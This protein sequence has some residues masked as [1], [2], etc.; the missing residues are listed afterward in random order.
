ME[1]LTHQSR[2]QHA[3]YLEWLT[4]WQGM[5]LM[6]GES[7][8]VQRPNPQI[9]I[10]KHSLFYIFETVLFLI[11]M[12]NCKHFIFFF[13]FVFFFSCFLLSVW[14]QKQNYNEQRHTLKISH[15]TLHKHLS[16]IRLEFLLL[17]ENT[18]Q[19][20]ALFSCQLHDFGR[21]NWRAFLLWA[22]HFYVFCTRFLWWY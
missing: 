17:G 16:D 10:K 5:S 12:V 7:R 2:G 15:D 11:Y 13:C 6:P 20:A 1:T 19:L 4:D 21:R 8:D 9:Q 14:Q 18:H 3:V 22:E